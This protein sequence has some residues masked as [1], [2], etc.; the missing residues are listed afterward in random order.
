MFQPFN[1]PYVNPGLD[2]TY[3]KG[4][5]FNISGQVPYETG[6]YDGIQTLL[7][8]DLPFDGTVSAPSNSPVSHAHTLTPSDG[9]N[10][11][12]QYMLTFATRF[13]DTRH[14]TT[15][16]QSI[17]RANE[18]LRQ[19][20]QYFMADVRDLTDRN[21]EAREFYAKLINNGDEW[22]FHNADPQTTKDDYYACTLAGIMKR[23]NFLGGLLSKGD[24]DE[25]SEPGNTVTA[26]VVHC[27]NAALYN[28]WS[29][30]VRLGTSLFLVI[31]RT[32]EGYF[33]IIPRFSHATQTLPPNDLVYEDLSGRTC[34]ARVIPVGI[35]TAFMDQ[36]M[37]DVAFLAEAAGINAKQQK[38][39]KN[40]LTLG[41]IVVQIGF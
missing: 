14:G 35:V 4:S 23:Y 27:R 26:S 33:Q 41:K 8:F 5:G 20:Y 34:R 17:F 28:I 30:N 16:G 10:Y 3:K 21:A 6:S 31:R 19:N 12:S 39:M 22:F 1:F 15:N 9:P 24:T 32:P 38:A 13:I 11:L 2:I 25:T 40:T 36:Q 29:P 18:V 37:G 7:P